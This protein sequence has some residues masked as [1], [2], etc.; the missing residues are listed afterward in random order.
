MSE[1]HSELYAQVFANNKAWVEEKTSADPDFFK[2][3]VDGQSPDFLFIGCAD[4]RVP[5]NVI[6]GLDPG[7]VFVHRNVAN[8][9]PNT[10]ANVMAVIQYAVEHLHVK[11]V[12]VCGHAGCGGVKAAMQA[13]DLGG[14]NGWL[15]EIRDVY[16]LHKDELDAIED[17]DARYNRLIELNVQE[18]VMAV[19]KTSFVQ[20]HY[21]DHGYPHVHGWVYDLADGLIKD[22]DID[23]TAVMAD[24]REIYRLKPS[25]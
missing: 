13:A 24:I 20:Q 22:L 17:E 1:K 19:S 18:Q 14:L 8:L 6:M 11:H 7:D 5:S 10:D 3:Q 25:S 2:R 23:F 4:S 9:V 15:R 16:R 12:V 21:L